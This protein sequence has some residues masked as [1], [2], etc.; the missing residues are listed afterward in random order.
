MNP[1]PKREVVDVMTA[2]NY[3]SVKVVPLVGEELR[4]KAHWERFRPQM[5]RQF[6]AQGPDALDTAVRKA[7]HLTEF[8]VMLAMARDPALHRWQAEDRLRNEWM[9]LPPESHTTP[10]SA[11]PTTT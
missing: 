9:W 2:D 6:Q 7:C 1:T 10:D 5:C 8:Q 11:H 4:V 3:P